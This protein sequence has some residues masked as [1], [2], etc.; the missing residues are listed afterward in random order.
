MQK[1]EMIIMVSIRALIYYEEQLDLL[2]VKQ[3][4]DQVNLPEWLIYD[5][6]LVINLFRPYKKSSETEDFLCLVDY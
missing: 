3:K 4:K 6:M 5:K 1:A 2:T